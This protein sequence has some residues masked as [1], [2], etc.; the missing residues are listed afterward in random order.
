MIIIPL[1]VPHANM[2]P[3]GFIDTDVKGSLALYVFT[4]LSL[5]K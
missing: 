1:D 5:K 3:S 4:I 2:E